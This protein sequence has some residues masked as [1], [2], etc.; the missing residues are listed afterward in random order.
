MFSKWLGDSF[1]FVLHWLCI[2]ADPAAV[3]NTQKWGTS[4]I[5]LTSVIQNNYPIDIWINSNIQSALS[6]ENS[7][8][9]AKFLGTIQYFN[10][11]KL[12]FLSL[13]Y[14]VGLDINA[15]FVI[16]FSEIFIIRFNVNI[17]LHQ[18]SKLPVR[19][20]VPKRNPVLLYQNLQDKKQNKSI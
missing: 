6:T 14:Y 17:S 11:H 20:L 13:W 16:T 9:I 1:R 7:L 3:I 8:P 10:I 18:K 2:Y 12:F 15:K 19:E 4:D 5:K